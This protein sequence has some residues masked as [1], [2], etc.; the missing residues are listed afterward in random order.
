MKKVFAMAMVETMKSKM[1]VHTWLVIVFAWCVLFVADSVKAQTKGAEVA[2]SDFYGSVTNGLYTNAFLGFE[3]RAPKSWS[4]LSQADQESAKSI[5]SDGLKEQGANNDKEIDQAVGA[6]TVVLAYAKKPLGAPGNS[7]IAL[8]IAKQP[9]NRI[10]PEM[11]A[12]AAKGLFLKSPENKLAQDIKIEEIGGKPFASFIIN[13]SIYG[14][15]VRLEYYATMVGH[16]SITISKVV[17]DERAASEA[18]AAL[19]SFKFLRK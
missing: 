11:V 16:Y 6:E 13:L 19:R 17:N 2:K 5:G 9:S 14:N 8:G 12:E 3:M 18:E 1:K 10:T 7:S 15:I 4:S